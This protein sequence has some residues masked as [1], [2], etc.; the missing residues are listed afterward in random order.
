MVFKILYPGILLYFTIL[1]QIKLADG[2]LPES[3]SLLKSS[4]VSWTLL[5]ILSDLNNAV[6]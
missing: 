1:I 5:S 2:L 6:V 4:Q 3:E